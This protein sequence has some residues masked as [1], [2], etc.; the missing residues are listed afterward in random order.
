MSMKQNKTF[1]IVILLLVLG[2]FMFSSCRPI[3]NNEKPEIGIND[4]CL[5]STH[6][7][8]NN[9]SECIRDGCS[10]EV[11]RSVHE[12]PVITTCVYKPCYDLAFKTSKC[13]CTPSGCEWITVSP[14]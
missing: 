3:Q 4:S 10:G 14:Q 8:C 1:L 9:D 6:G 11:C 12:E 2:S 13:S 7:S 5:I